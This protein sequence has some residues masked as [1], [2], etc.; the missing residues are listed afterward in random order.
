[1]NPFVDG[2]ELQR[3]FYQTGCTRNVKWRLDQLEKLRSELKKHEPAMMDALWEDFRKPPFETFLTE[4]AALMQE[5]KWLKRN[6]LRW[7]RPA[8]VPTNL[9][10]LPG[11]SRIYHEPYGQSLII[12]SYNYPFLLTLK[13]LISSLA[14]GNT[15]MVKP[16]ELVVNSSALM[17]EMLETCFTPEYVKVV[18]GGVEESSNLLE[19][20]FQ[21]VFFTG[22]SRVGKIVMKAAAEHLSHLTLELGGKSPALI[23]RDADLEK[24]AQRIAWGKFINAGQ[25]CIAPDYVLI[26][27]EDADIFLSY[28]SAQLKRMY[29][30]QPLNSLHYASIVNQ[31][32][33]QRLKAL[34]DQSSVFY[35]GSFDSETKRISPTILYPCAISEP[36]MQEEIFGPLLPVITY[37]DDDEAL[38]IIQSHEVP[39]AFYLFSRSSH[40]V[41]KWFSMVSFGG[42]CVNDV[43]MHIGNPNLPFGGRGSSGMGKYH[44][45]AGLEEFSHSRS[46]LI[47]SNWFEPYFKYPPYTRAK[48]RIMRTILK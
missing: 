1:M 33:F 45:Q 11:R 39:L 37:R 8:R 43:V 2:F 38:N 22:S 10:N 46:V 30:Q 40:A 9:P 26:H 27:E 18:E 13:P 35:G 15:A 31:H 47:H 44:R 19:L 34:V 21:K 5:I 14:A 20:P 4:T 23:L 48:L 3:D 28:L 12:G 41:K 6:L 29:G 17:R 25:T 24:A 16:S 7:S 36:V 42:G 32:H